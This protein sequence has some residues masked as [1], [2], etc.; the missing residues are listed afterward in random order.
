M[1]SLIDIRSMSDIEKI[2]ALS[3]YTWKNTSNLTSINLIEE[4]ILFNFF[5]K[6]QHKIKFITTQTTFD[7]NQKSVSISTYT[8][9]DLESIISSMLSHEKFFFVFYNIY[10]L[11]TVSNDESIIIRGEFIEDIEEIRNM[12]INDIVN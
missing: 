3:L 11:Q 8:A 9:S 2:S 12:K 4:S 7:F 1:E 10:K 6:L 5:N